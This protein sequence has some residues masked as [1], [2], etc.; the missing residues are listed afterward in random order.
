MSKRK[1]AAKRKGLGAGIIAFGAV[2]ALFSLIFRPHTP[3]A[4]A[5]A[6]A[7]SLFG[8]AVVRVMAQGLDLSTPSRESESLQKVQ[9]Q[10]GDPEVD[11][12]LTGYVRVIIGYMEEQICPIGAERQ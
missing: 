6:F 8:G 2:F 7:L 11:R 3:G 1:P 4:F 12:M 9:G 10:T 5:L